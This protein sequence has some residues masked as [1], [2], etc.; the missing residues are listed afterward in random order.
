[1]KKAK[2]GCFNIFEKEKDIKSLERDYEKW[3]LEHRVDDKMDAGDRPGR[4][5]VCME[6]WYA[7]TKFAIEQIWPMHSYQR[8]KEQAR[9]KDDGSEED[10]K[11]EE[12]EEAMEKDS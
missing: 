5:R 11:D 12:G 1:M 9:E 3:N 8:S 4:T 6:K 7:N 2:Y 10:K